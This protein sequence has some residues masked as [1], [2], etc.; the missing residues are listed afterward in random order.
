MSGTEKTQVYPQSRFPASKE[1]AA[2]S[3]EV[4]TWLKSGESSV[5]VSVAIFA[6]VTVE[7]TAFVVH[8]VVEFLAILPWLGSG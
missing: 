1:S 6:T 3:D 8:V 4:C 7:T 2:I 5:I